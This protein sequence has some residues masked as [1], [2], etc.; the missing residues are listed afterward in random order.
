[1]HIK[2]DRLYP[3]EYITTRI[4]FPADRLVIDTTQ[5]NLYG[6]D[7][8]DVLYGESGNDRLSG[9]LGDDQ[10][11]GDEG[12]DLLDGGAGNDLLSGGL[13][14]DVYRFYEGAGNDIIVDTGGLDTIVFDGI[15]DPSKLNY[16]R[17]GNDLRAS[18]KTSS[19]S[20]TIQNF[21]LADGSLN[22]S[23][24]VDNFRLAN[25]LTL[26]ANSLVNAMASAPR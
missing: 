17:L 5:D 4:N 2:A 1:V 14:D 20:I 25:G 12:S 6:N 23:A 7:G 18:F 8:N 16:Q 9:G 13:G 26:S 24:A 10:L 15:T 19:D 22:T 3:D 11:Y 21:F